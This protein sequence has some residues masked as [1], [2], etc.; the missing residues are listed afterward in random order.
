MNVKPGSDLSIPKVLHLNLVANY[1]VHHLLI[2]G[3]CVNILQSPVSKPPV[4]N[5][6]VYFC[7]MAFSVATL[8]K[9]Q[10]HYAI[11]FVCDVSVSKT[12]TQTLIV[13]AVLSI[14]W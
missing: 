9:R 1:L 10:S 11:G 4:Y 12:K 13:G 5:I 3:N 2:G 14:L 8:N 6:W 7:L